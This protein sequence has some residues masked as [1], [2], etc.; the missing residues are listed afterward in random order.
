LVF[1]SPVQEALTDPLAALTGRALA[2]H[3]DPLPT[4]ARQDLRHIVSMYWDNIDAAVIDGQRRVFAKL[5]YAIKQ[6]NAT[7]VA[8]GVWIDETLAAAGPDDLILFVDIDAFP[9]TAAAIG[10]AFSAA[11]AGRIFGVAQTA[12]HLPER[13]FIYVGPA[14]LCLARRC[15]EAIGRPSAVPDAAND[16]AMRIGKAAISH[17]VSLELLYPNYVVIPRWQLGGKGVT[18]YGTFYG[19]G[20]VFHLFEARRTRRAGLR[21]ILDQVVAR[22]VAGEE[23]DYVALYEAAHSPRFRL[24]AFLLYLKRRAAKTRRMALRRLGA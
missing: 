6:I 7:G 8:H 10:R 1:W 13:D 24:G 20:S 16:V 14:F 22:V 5:G 23:I 12:S 21:Q 15:W 3:L 19:E 4:R 11:E 18:G 17:G 9:L 2:D